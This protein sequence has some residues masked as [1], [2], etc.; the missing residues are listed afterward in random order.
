MRESALAPGAKSL[1]PA[2]GECMWS[3]INTRNGVKVRPPGIEDRLELVSLDLVV[4]HHVHS[5]GIIILGLEKA[6]KHFTISL[7]FFCFGAVATLAAFAV[8][9][10]VVVVIDTI[11]VIVAT[12]TSTASRSLCRMSSTAALNLVGKSN[13]SSSRPGVLSSHIWTHLEI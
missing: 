2:I 12:P 13:P 5:L 4:V 11:D 1:V 9:F 8:L 6:Q 10:A 3:L 7:H